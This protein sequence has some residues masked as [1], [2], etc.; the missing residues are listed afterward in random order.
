MDDA[1]RIAKVLKSGD[2]AVVSLRNTPEALGKRILDFSFG[3]GMRLRGSG[4]MRFGPRVRYHARRG[5]ERCRGVSPQSPRVD[6]DVC[7]ALF[8]VKLAD[9]YH[10]DSAR[11]CAHELD[12]DRSG[13][14]ADIETVLGKVCDPYLNLFRKF[15]PPIG[16]MVDV[17][18][19]FALLV[20]QFLVLADCRHS[21]AAAARICSLGRKASCRLCDSYRRPPWVSGV[22]T[23]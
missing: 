21:L 18:P 15:I 14:L 2:V 17:T 1:E 20:L 19:I 22:Y 4:R 6:V 7:P 8:I 9:A 11:V 23:E 3:V 13:I 12:S 10:D 5:L 16:G